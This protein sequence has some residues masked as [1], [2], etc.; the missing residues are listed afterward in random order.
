MAK[1]N[2]S[3][4][5]VVWNPT[6][7]C[8]K[9][10]TGCEHCYAVPMAARLDAMGQQPYK[11]LTAR[12]GNGML[13]WTGVVRT[14]PERLDLPLRWKKPRRVFVNSMSDLFH[15]IVSSEFL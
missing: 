6:V 14:L 1:T 12:H 10:A 9:I 5:D 15:E 13:D 11:G 2:I 8:A 3:W 4:T 7:G